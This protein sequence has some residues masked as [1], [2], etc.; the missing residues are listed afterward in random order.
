[1]A[2]ISMFL[3][4]QHAKSISLTLSEHLLMFQFLLSI[5]N[6]MSK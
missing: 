3:I 2:T 6:K 4:Y 5:E 1:M